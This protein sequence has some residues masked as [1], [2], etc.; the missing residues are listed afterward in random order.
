MKKV[1]KFIIFNKK[2]EIFKKAF[3]CII[4]EY[5]MQQAKNNKI[6]L[7]RDY[8]STVEV[9]NSCYLRVKNSNNTN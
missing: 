5:G 8:D 3:F 1:K 9:T 6:R 4:R 2:T 7:D